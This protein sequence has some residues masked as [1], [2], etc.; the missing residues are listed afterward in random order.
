MNTNGRERIRVDS[1]PFVVRSL[2]FFLAQQNHADHRHEE[3]DGNDFKRQQIIREQQLAERGGVDVPA[4]L[5]VRGDVAVAGG[6]DHH[7]GE[8]RL[9]PGLVL[10]DHALDG[11]AAHQRPRAGEHLEAAGG[12]C[13]EHQHQRRFVEVLD[14]AG[15]YPDPAAADHRDAGPRCGHI[16]QEL[17]R[18]AGVTGDV[19]ADDATERRVLR[20][21]E[22]RSAAARDRG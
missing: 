2:Q 12:Q 22:I 20:T 21:E 3:Q 13:G 8:D 18:R 5:H 10:D 9:P 16:G 6:V 19:L 15:R 11:V 14:A 4:H 7:L 17:R 1:C